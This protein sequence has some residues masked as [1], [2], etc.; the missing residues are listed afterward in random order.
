MSKESARVSLTALNLKL[1]LKID[2]L[3][4]FVIFIAAVIGVALA[5]FFKAFF[6][7]LFLAVFALIF[8]VIF[9]RRGKIILSDG[10]LFLAFL[11]SFA[12]WGATA[13]FKS[14]GD[15][16][17]KEHNFT[18]TVI[19]LPREMAHCNLL[20][21]E[22][23]NISGAA[24]K[25]QVTLVDYTK[26]L[27]Y[28]KRYR[29][30][31]RAGVVE[32]NSRSHT[33]LWIKKD[34]EVTPAP[35]GVVLPL[36]RAFNLYALQKF[37]DN[38]HDGEARFLSALLLGRYEL[39]KKERQFFIDAGVSHLLAISGL[40]MTLVSIVLFFIFG[41]LYCPYRLRLCLAGICIYA[42][43]IFSGANPSAMRAAWMCLAF[44]ATFLSRK[45][46]DLL[47]A[48]GLAGVISLLLDPKTLF[49]IGFEFSYLSVFA[50][51]VGAKI[52]PLDKES[53][54]VMGFSKNSLFISFWLSLVILPFTAYYFERIYPEA[55]IFNLFL[56][57]FCNLIFL[58]A[59]IFLILSPCAALAAPLAAVLGILSRWFVELNRLCSITPGAFLPCK[60]DT[61][62][63]VIYYIILAALVVYLRK[64]IIKQNA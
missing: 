18:F 31:A 10:C 19:S 27:Q 21:G 45:K 20:Q 26:T 8:A 46:S 5:S 11:F 61:S 63:V 2:N 25:T 39:L 37:K 43:G 23:R 38:F 53:G 32:R 47:N 64:S 13:Y 14:I 34:S 6:I 22:I 60:L 42:Y 54:K 15:F 50:L 35:E 62:G 52:F 40:H 44:A 12:V 57:P 48:L 28:L 58:L 55:V 17:G 30:A 3:L 51:I 9:G 41:L 36:S 24:I 33:Y 59:F 7:F 1:N 56:V 49:Y 4:P 16:T 29:A